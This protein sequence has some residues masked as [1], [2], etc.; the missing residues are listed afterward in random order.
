MRVRG[1]ATLAGAIAVLVFGVTPTGAGAQL[2]GGHGSTGLRLCDGP[3]LTDCESVELAPIGLPM[4]LVNS[5][6]ELL[7]LA[8]TRQPLEG[9]GEL[10]ICDP[11][12]VFGPGYEVPLVRVEA[13]GHTAGVKTINLGSALASEHALEIAVDDQRVQVVSDCSH[14][15]PDPSEENSFC[16]P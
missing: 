4:N 6:A 2:L 7:C 15:P 5:N 11:P 3:N 14:Y 16:V 8:S 12:P 13:L 1:I 10:G 9:V